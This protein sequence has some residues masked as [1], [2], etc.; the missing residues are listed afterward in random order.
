MRGP[1]SSFFMVES[2]ADRKARLLKDMP[3]A[4]A[5]HQAERATIDA[6][7]V[8]LRDLRL[9]RDAADSAARVLARTERKT[10]GAVAQ[11][12]LKKRLGYRP[13]L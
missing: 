3:V 12:V 5:A 7:T 4:W 1:H 2:S 10:R 11:A 8:K 6:R 13:G 9:A